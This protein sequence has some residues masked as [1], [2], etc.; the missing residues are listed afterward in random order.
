MRTTSVLIQS[1][2]VPCFNHCRHCLL[3]WNGHTEGAS[4]ERSIA[5]AERLLDELR[6]QMPEVKSS[7]SFGYSMEHPDLSG[8]IRTLCALGSPMAD[9]LQCDGMRMRDGNACLEL[10]C[11]LRAEGIRQLNFT[12]YGLSD[13]HDRFAGRTG[14]FDLLL[15]MMKAAKAS[16]LPFSTGIPLTA[17]NIH[18]V[19]DLVCLLQNAGSER[20]FLTIPH[21]EGRGK[22]LRDVRLCKQDFLG[23]AAETQKLLDNTIYR[24]EGEWLRESEPVSDTQRM[25]LISLRKDNMDAYERRSAMSIV[26]EIEA[27]DENYYSSFPDFH[28]LSAIYGDPVGEKLYRIRDL[29]Y[30][31]R[32][33]YAQAHGIHVYDVTDERQSGSRRH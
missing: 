25:I 5:I 32:V 8:A 2:C 3:S 21:E 24:T 22:L 7:F 16:S 20:V 9:F 19:D 18:T 27:L 13:Y 28:E 15:R 14:D 30:H 1:L 17:D 33:Q 26:R 6:V 31:Y 29:Y 23:L 12:L 4:W 11:M 10:M